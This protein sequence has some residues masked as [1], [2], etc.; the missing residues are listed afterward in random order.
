[1]PS[2]FTLEGPNL[3]YTQ[4]I[5]VPPAAGVL[6]DASQPAWYGVVGLLALTVVGWYGYQRYKRRGG[7]F[8]PD[9]LSTI[10]KE[11][12]SVDEF[13]RRAEAWNAGNAK[14]LSDEA[15]ARKFRKASVGAIRKARREREAGRDRLFQRLAH[16]LKGSRKPSA[17]SERKRQI[18]ELEHEREH[19]FQAMAYAGNT[20]DQVK[21]YHA[22]IDE[23]GDR[24]RALRTGSGLKG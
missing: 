14:K 16:G 4:A 3:G 1:M 21:R 23:I 5:P 9:M 8:G 10:A 17:A 20:P 12:R 2:I 19:V 11:S 24:L 22:M 18:K 15:L 13:A 7:L 6:R